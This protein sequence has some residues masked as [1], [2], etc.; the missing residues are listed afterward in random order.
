M[1]FHFFVI[2]TAILTNLL[3]GAILEN[4]KASESLPLEAK[5]IHT[6][7]AA[8]KENEKFVVEARVDGATSRVVYMRLY[9]KSKDGGSYD[10]VEMSRS[11]SGYFAE[12]G[13]RYVSPPELHY[14]ILTLLEDRTVL[15]YPTWNPYGNPVV[16]SVASASTPVVEPKYTESSSPDVPQE[17]TVPAESVS[18]TDEPR[19]R[20][21]ESSDL[22][23]ES[24]VLILSPEQGEEF[25]VGEEVVIA[26]SFLTGES[27]IDVNSI[28]LFVDGLNVTL[29]SDVTENLLTFTTSELP[30]GKHQVLVQGHYAS[31]AALP[32]TK[33]TFRIVGERRQ[34]RS[35][36]LVQG[37]VFA[38]SRHEEIS[39]V[40]FHDNNI[41]GFLS[42]NYGIAKYKAR[43]YLTTRESGRFQPRHRYSFDVQV[44]ILG[45]T[46]GDTYPRFNDLMLWGKRV[47]GVHGRLHFG[48]F[49]LDLVHG[50]TVRKVSA[51]RDSTGT[52]TRFG[53]H[54]RKLLGIR[55][56]WGSGRHFQLGFNLLKVRDDT[57]SLA[58]GEFSTSPKDNLVFGSD[59]FLSLDNRRIELRAA[60]AFS[61]LS[62]DI[63]NGPASRDDV[64]E[65]FD[66]ELPFDPAGFADWLII[67][68]STTPLDPRDLTSLAYNFKLRLNYFNNN[69]QFG[70]K[71]IGSEYV[72]FGNS[73]LRGNIRGFYLNDR[74][75]LF[76]NKVSVNLG[77]E[78][79]LDNFDPD[80]RNPDTK[81]RTITTGLSIFPGR[82]LPN[83]TFNL[84]NH[85]R[86]NDIDSLFFDNTGTLPDTTDIREN[87]NTRDL[88]V[89]LSHD[90]NFHQ[91][92]NSITLS[93]IT[94]DRD[95]A[96]GESRPGGI[97]NLT[98]TSSNV[99]LLS[100]RTQYQ[101]PLVT[102][103]N[104][105][106]NDNQF[107]G[108][109]NEFNFKSFGAKAEYSLLDRRLHTYFGTNFTTAS[110]NTVLTDSTASVTDYNRIDFSLGARWEISRG[111]FVHIDGHLIRFSDSG[112]R[113]NTKQGAFIRTN[114][115]FTDR[116][117][118]FYY[119]KRF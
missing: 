91:L 92:R 89:Q 73:F 36:P 53:T 11:S 3:G 15:T 104:F 13:P 109:R 103:I 9:F 60:G 76:Q 79:Y 102:T 107:A 44:P 20:T 105:S 45:I 59:I 84:R 10:Y 2:L 119:E 29:E 114:P 51:L 4:A 116:I 8:L 77:L 6:P 40:G 96:F 117:F 94:S 39:N 5:I 34:R 24:P 54:R 112:G 58:A 23:Q 88:T 93:Y 106:R 86:D 42:G 14:F 72:S 43:V 30:P 78:N 85:N 17:A 69:L 62:N 18:A 26:A 41:G 27:E 22:D 7:V 38:E 21:T 97:P 110:G 12:L 71:S 111:H 1:K 95:D 61:L 31:G 100:V 66:V 80:N 98:E 101:I 81:L 48:F 74:F 46:V 52:V 16:V 25:N 67:N 32:R 70:Y 115:S 35:E 75:R 87:N 55:Q 63:S 28:N 33:W 64:E 108:G 90:V 82:G 50:E 37:R 56:S 49:N 65:Q 47:R 57:T 99:Q 83:L 19:T 68:S 113:F 118:R